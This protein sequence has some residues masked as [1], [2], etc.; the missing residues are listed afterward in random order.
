MGLT[1]QQK[2][3]RRWR[4]YMQEYRAKNRNRLN[5][6][7]REY[8]GVHRTQIL[9]R[10]RKTDKT[11]YAALST[12]A[13]GLRNAEAREYGKAYRRRLKEEVIVAYGGRCVCCGEEHFEFL[14]ID[15]TANNGSHER[16]TIAV[17][18]GYRFYL[19]LKRQGFP[20]KGYRLLCFNCNS[21]R[22]F[23]GYCPHAKMK[24][25]H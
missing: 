11:R 6:K 10:K 17:S 16:R 14:S 21:A 4:K 2:H 25:G 15:H 9:T 18:A 13:R 7:S 8:H 12:K 24:R 1:W 3:P 5:E 20:K 23:Y 22:G 19:Y